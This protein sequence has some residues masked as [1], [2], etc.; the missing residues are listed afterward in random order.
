MKND[1]IKL[2]IIIPIYNAEKY[3]ER[4]IDSILLQSFQDF[5]LI[6]VNDGS[7]DRSRFICES[8]AQRDNRVILINKPNG[9]SSSAKN[10]GLSH[11]RGQ[12]IEF[13][14]ADDYLDKEYI[15]HLWTGCDEYDAD[16]C[17]GNVSFTKI[18]NSD[19]KSKK[20]VEMK[21]GYF[22][23]KDFLMFYPQ[24]MPKAIIGAPW[25]KLYK[26]EIIDAY[27][28]KFD[29]KIKNNED[30]H[31][32]YWYL[33]K[34]SSVYVSDEPY[35]NYVDEN[36]SSASR[37]YIPNLFDIYLMTYDKAIKFLKDT[38]VYEHN[39][40]FQRQY[41]IN[42]VIGAMNQIVLCK[43]RLSRSDKLK[44]IKKIVNNIKVEEAVKNIRYADRK[45]QIL[46]MLMKKKYYRT[47]YLMILMNYKIKGKDTAKNE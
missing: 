41:F 27:E 8:Y 19:I 1:L 36:V 5:E 38:G 44:Q 17:I 40:G 28:I 16:V 26:K 37:S 30:T 31:F 42:L 12:Y 29:T 7:T 24:Y 32:N 15:E 4:C 35:Y 45:K 18:R 23:L 9:G 39:I 2:S 43:N 11:A 3:L 46:L 34:C 20:H 33:S 22:T 13:V 25:N 21:R 14:D 10:I 47:I 6:L